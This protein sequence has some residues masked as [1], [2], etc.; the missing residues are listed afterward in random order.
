[1]VSCFFAVFSPFFSKNFST[2]KKYGF[3]HQNNAARSTAVAK[4]AVP[5]SLHDPAQT[6]FGERFARMVAAQL[7]TDGYGGLFLFVPV[8]DVKPVV[9]IDYLS[10]MPLS[11]ILFLTKI[12]G[13]FY[14][15]ETCLS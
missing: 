3:L 15:A 4:P 6:W 13:F 12:V 8:W 9:K 1:V 11:F 5:T 7:L 2:G 14:D 10:K